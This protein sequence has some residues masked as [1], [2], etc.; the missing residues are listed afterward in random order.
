[1]ASRHLRAVGEVRATPVTL[2][3]SRVLL[4]IATDDPKWADWSG[5]VVTVRPR[6]GRL[7]CAW[8]SGE[9]AW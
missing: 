6:P 4:D 5:E 7:V 8:R 1:M 9:G 2:V 3:D